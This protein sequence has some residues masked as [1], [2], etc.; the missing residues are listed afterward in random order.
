[1]RHHD[2][3]GMHIICNKILLTRAS[4]QTTNRE[5]SRLYVFSGFSCK[6]ANQQSVQR[7]QPSQS[8]HV[9]NC[10]GVCECFENLQT[11]IMHFAFTMTNCWL[12]HIYMHTKSASAEKLDQ[13]IFD[14]FQ[15]VFFYLDGCFSWAAQP[16]H[17]DSNKNM[18]CVALTK[19]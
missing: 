11:E 14:Q 17:L 5:L 7:D 8:V 2:L 3:L 15:L 19:I 13:E 12:T 10:G 16:F 1:V 4:T 9:W 6:I 18:I